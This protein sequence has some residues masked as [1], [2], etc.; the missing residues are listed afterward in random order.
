M[1]A[2]LQIL[3][4]SSR[5]ADHAVHRTFGHLEFDPNAAFELGFEPFD[6]RT[7]SRQ[8]DAALADVGG[9]IWGSS[10]SARWMKSVM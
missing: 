3:Q 1:L 6:E 7:A 8:A 9:D 5:T 4:D 2:L 10:T